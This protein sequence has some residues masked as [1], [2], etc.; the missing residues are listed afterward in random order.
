MQE[1]KLKTLTRQ[2]EIDPEIDNSIVVTHDYYSKFP[3]L[4]DEELGKCIAQKGTFEEIY[5][6]HSKYDS[7]KH[8]ALI[9]KVDEDDKMPWNIVWVENEKLWIAFKYAKIVDPG[10]A[11]GS[12]VE[13]AEPK[14]S[15]VYHISKYVAE[16]LRQSYNI[17]SPLDKVYCSAPKIN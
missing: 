11:Y 2:G 15:K 14:R 6:G 5:R 9:I 8:T 16:L 7:S 10:E 4:K 3:I 13:V 1:L 12:T 17:N